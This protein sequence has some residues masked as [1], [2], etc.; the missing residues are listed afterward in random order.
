VPPAHAP[1]PASDASGNAFRWAAAG[2][3]ATLAML[4]LGR[5]LRRALVVRH[6]ARP[7]WRESI[8]QQ[9]SNHWHRMLIGLRDAGICP[10]RGEP[11]ATFARRVG[12][13]GMERCSQILERARHGVRIEPLD[14]QAMGA[15]SNA[16]YG[17][18][19]RRAGAMA[20][21]V[22]WFRARLA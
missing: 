16:V 15:S 11:P 14:L 5:V 10:L 21:V 9:I 18:A 4:L 3:G 20:R 13:E 17:A 7:F 8:D 12:I 19:R 2:A 22:G 6:L 1:T